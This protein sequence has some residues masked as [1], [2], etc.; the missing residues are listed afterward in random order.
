VIAY[1]VRGLNKPYKAD[2]NFCVFRSGFNLR[3][4]GEKFSL[5]P[6][7]QRRMTND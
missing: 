5:F 6:F 7:I 2:K 1:E 3:E 4:E